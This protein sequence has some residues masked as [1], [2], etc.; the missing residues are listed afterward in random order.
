MGIPGPVLMEASDRHRRIDYAAV[1]RSTL[2]GPAHALTIGICMHVVHAHHAVADG[3]LRSSP[4]RGD[5][6]AVAS[7]PT[8]YSRQTL[9]IRGAMPYGRDAL[10]ISGGGVGARQIH[11]DD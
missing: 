5:A 1:P 11:A 4:C 9:T 7:S 3:R 10:L 2:G 6:R 8:S